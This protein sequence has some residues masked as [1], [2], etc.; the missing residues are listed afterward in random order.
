M[1]EQGPHIY[2]YTESEDAG[3]GS[4]VPHY[5]STQPE[6]AGDGSLVPNHGST[7]GG[8]G[9]TAVGPPKGGGARLAPNDGSTVVDVLTSVVVGQRLSRRALSLRTRE[10]TRQV[11]QRRRSGCFGPPLGALTEKEGEPPFAGC[12]LCWLRPLRV[13]P[14]AGSA[15]CWLESGAAE[16]HH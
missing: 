12:A 9:G 10:V 6:E 15:L 13:A 2:I 8:T 3:D 16:A 11:L 5:G 4:L 1:Y 14:F 7:G